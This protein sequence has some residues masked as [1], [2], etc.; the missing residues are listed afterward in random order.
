MS[1]MLNLKFP[2][3]PSKLDIIKLISKVIPVTQ[4]DAVLNLFPLTSI[5]KFS[6]EDIVQMKK[7]GGWFHFQKNIISEIRYPKDDLIIFDTENLVRVS[8]N[9]CMATAVGRNGYYI[10]FA[11]WLYSEGTTKNLIPFNNSIFMAHNLHFDATKIASKK[12][13]SIGICTYHIAKFMFPNLKKHN[14][15]NIAKNLLGFSLD[16]SLRDF[17]VEKG[18]S[19]FKDKENG[20]RLAHY[21]L[22]DTL[23]SYKLAAKISE[24]LLA[25][26]N[27]NDIAF[28]FNIAMYNLKV[29]KKLRT[30]HTISP[31]PKILSMKLIKIP[32]YAATRTLKELALMLDV[33]Q[34][35][36]QLYYPDLISQLLQ[37]SFYSFWIEKDNNAFVDSLKKRSM[38]ITIDESNLTFSNRLACQLYIDRVYHELVGKPCSKVHLN[39]FTE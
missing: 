10:W 36:S 28:H 35:R 37:L 18:I 24:S 30:S 32:N 11:P 9:S 38:S 3:D 20:L 5:P 6:S 22:E 31:S 17:F 33:H 27:S 2:M 7:K 34:N 25:T 16:K 26:S 4:K 19:E 13:N 1:T 15:A 29:Q 23:A 14:L 21:C 8:A 39:I 12:S